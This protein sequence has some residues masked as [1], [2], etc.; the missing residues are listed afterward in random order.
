MGRASFSPQEH[1]DC[2]PSYDFSFFT[3]FYATMK[4]T[5]DHLEGPWRKRL[6]EG[7][8]G[9]QKAEKMVEQ[10]P[11]GTF[12]LRF[13]DSQLGSLETARGY[14]TMTV[15]SGQ[16]IVAGGYNSSWTN[17]SGLLTSVETL[18]G[19]HWAQ[20]N[21]LKVG[22]NYHTALTIEAGKILC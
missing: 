15:V 18:N 13:S 8:V 17:T 1:K 20:S 11:P 19:T 22:R 14:H 16:M 2:P 5:L 10:R 7:F 4:T 3:W 21:N 12:L 9:R 6:V